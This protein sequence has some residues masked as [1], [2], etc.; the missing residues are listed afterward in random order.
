VVLSLNF[1]LTQSPNWSSNNKMSEEMNYVNCI[2]K[3]MVA[4]GRLTEKDILYNT[5]YKLGW[6]TSIYNFQRFGNYQ[7]WKL[8]IDCNAES[9][10]TYYEPIF[11]VVFE[12][13]LLDKSCK[14]IYKPQIPNN[15]V[16]APMAKP[17]SA[18]VIK[19]ASTNR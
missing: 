1:D 14:A 19:F 3:F 8:H 2:V 13:L 16:I 12:V 9:E 4:H 18:P 6:I 7:G 17:V 5:L 11:N 15:V 10:A